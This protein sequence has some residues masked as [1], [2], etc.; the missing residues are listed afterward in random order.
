[1]VPYF[2]GKTAGTGTVQKKHRHTERRK[3]KR[4]ERARRR[5]KPL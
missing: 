4:E 3:Y 5:R 1:M 2:E